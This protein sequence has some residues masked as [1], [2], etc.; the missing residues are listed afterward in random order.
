MKKIPL[1]V[2]A[3]PTASGK[4]ALAVETAKQIDG[5]VI[6]A[7]SV[8]VYRYLNIGSAKPSKEE[9]SGIPHHL[10]DIVDPDTAF[11]VADYAL[12][13]HE[14][15]QS[16]HARG[17]I[18]ILAGGT[19][20]YIDAVVR[21]ISFGEME[22]DETLRS[23]LERLAKEKGG[24]YLLNILKQFDE[25]SARRLHENNVRRIIRAIEFYRI[26][27]VTISQHQE[28]T[29]HKESRYHTCMFG[30]AWDRAILY[31]RINQRVERMLENG[32]IDEVRELTRKGYTKRMNAMQGIGY[33]EVIDYLRGFL[34][35]DE[36]VSVMKRDTRRYA[37]RQMTWFRREQN[38]RWLDYDS[39]ITQKLCETAR[40]ELNI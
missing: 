29:K 32:L 8:Q 18:P 2:I 3:G 37:K 5:E 6:S 28:Q 27:G 39:D 23:D 17:K 7:D 25:V 4:T 33:K 38:M 16:V 31:D 40:R 14:A 13:A 30:I 12:L 11:S 1:I 26:T 21:D 9:M 36:M 15:I 22:T 24:A 35:Y 10:I 34:T 20:L 19:G